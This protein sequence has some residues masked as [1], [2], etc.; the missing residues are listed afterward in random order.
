MYRILITALLF[1]G[2]ALAHP[3]HGAPTL[4]THGWEY[5]LLAATAAAA[6]GWLRARK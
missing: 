4:H 2:E 1:S 6:W 5:A 3:G